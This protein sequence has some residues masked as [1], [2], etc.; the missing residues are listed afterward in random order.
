MTLTKLLW[1]D[2]PYR[3]GTAYAACIVV[4]RA[5]QGVV[6]NNEA[7]V[8]TLVAAPASSIPLRFSRYSMIVLSLF[9]LSNE[10]YLCLSFFL[11]EIIKLIG[12]LAASN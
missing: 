12:E 10:N 7:P 2:R 6:F 8:P 11:Q 3:L 4:V 5:A 9:F 1:V